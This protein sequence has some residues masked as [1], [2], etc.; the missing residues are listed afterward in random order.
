MFVTLNIQKMT[1]IPIQYTKIL[2]AFPVRLRLLCLLLLAG[3][4]LQAQTLRRNSTYDAYI[5]RY[6][7][8]AIREMKQY[9]I[10]ASITLAQGLL[11]S[12]AGQSELARR[13]NNHFGIKCADNWTGRRVYHDDDARG[14]CFRAYSDPKE[15]YADHSRFLRN[16]SRYASLFQLKLTDYK[17]WANGLKAAGY[18]TDPRYATRLINLIETYELYRYDTGSTGIEADYDYTPYTSNGLLYVKARRGDTLKGIAKEFDTSVRKLR[19]WNDLY[20]GYTLQ[21]GD[22]IYL[23]KKKRKAA[24]GTIVHTL[25]SGESMYSVA[26]T[27]GIRLKNLYKMNHLQ[28]EDAAPQAGTILRLR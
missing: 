2:S 21:E 22:I 25:R 8:V 7:E 1:N 10:P 24:K 16:R 15:S 4:A 11:E 19:S 27:Y 20:K 14:E 12:G 18:A 26:Q 28:P 3:T 5:Q 9:R 17:G 13:S 6:K 23:E